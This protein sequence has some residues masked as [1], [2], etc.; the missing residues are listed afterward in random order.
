MRTTKEKEKY[1]IKHMTEPSKSVKNII[2][3]YEY[4]HNPKKPQKAFRRLV[5]NKCKSPSPQ[6]S[7]RRRSYPLKM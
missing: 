4:I 7:D 3:T 2:Y 1:E 5:Q 6:K